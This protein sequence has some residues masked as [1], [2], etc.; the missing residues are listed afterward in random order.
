MPHQCTECGHLFEDGSA[1]MLDGCPDC[2]G[3]KF[4]FRPPGWKPASSSASED[5]SV[6]ATH[7]EESRSEEDGDEILEAPTDED[8]AQASARSDIVESDELP[9]SAESQAWGGWPGEE[10]P[11]E[12]KEREGTPEDPYEREAW[13]QEQKEADIAALREE[14]NRQFGSIKILEPGEYELNLMELY[15]RDE[16]IIALQEDGRY[17]IQMPGNWSD[18]AND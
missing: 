7:T 4:Q 3:K 5:Q 15:D 12:P 8:F 13:E 10:S 1:E 17:M 16:Y 9:D 6:E 18:K 11:G 14:L 2:G